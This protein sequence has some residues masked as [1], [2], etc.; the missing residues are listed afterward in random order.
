MAEIKGGLCR[1]D[2][3]AGLVEFSSRPLLERAMGRRFLRCRHQQQKH[4]LMLMAHWCSRRGRSGR[5]GCQSPSLVVGVV[6]KKKS[7]S[8]TQG[9]GLVEVC[10]L[11]AN[12]SNQQTC[13]QTTDSPRSACPATTVP[14]YSPCCH[15][16][17]SAFLSQTRGG[18]PGHRSAGGR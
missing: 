16:P 13:Q 17:A 1:C 2:I 14:P 15:T 9:A 18:R 11:Q 5:R 4:C 3:A 7:T 10:V 8:V 6:E 12:K